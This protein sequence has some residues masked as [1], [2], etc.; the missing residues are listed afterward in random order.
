MSEVR[1]DPNS[2]TWVAVRFRAHDE[3]E[4]AQRQLETPGLP[5][6][7]TEQLRGFIRAWRQVL[8]MQDERLQPIAS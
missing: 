5:V 8:S 2:M 6:A 1:I 3:I 4:R 7:E